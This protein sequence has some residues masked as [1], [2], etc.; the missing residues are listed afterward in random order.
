[1]QTE[2]YSSMRT[3]VRALNELIMQSDKDIWRFRRLFIT[4][5]SSSYVLILRKNSTSLIQRTEWFY[6]LLQSS[7]QS[8]ELLSTANEC[9]TICGQGYDVTYCVEGYKESSDKICFIEEGVACTRLM[10]RTPALIAFKQTQALK[11]I[12]QIQMQGLMASEEWVEKYPNPAER[13]AKILTDLK[14]VII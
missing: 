7:L 13:F 3:R 1:M 5:N 14:K 9:F 10:R 11:E 8:D 2:E 6:N 4:S 12:H